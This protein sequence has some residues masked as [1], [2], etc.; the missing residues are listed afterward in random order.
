MLGI[1]PIDK[2]QLNYTFWSRNENTPIFQG[3]KF[4]MQNL[5]SS[6]LLFFH[7]HL[8]LH[9]FHDFLNV[10]YVTRTRRGS[11][12]S[13]EPSTKTSGDQIKQKNGERSTSQSTKNY[14][15]IRNEF[16]LVFGCLSWKRKVVGGQAS[17][18]ASWSWVFPGDAQ[19]RMGQSKCVVHSGRKLLRLSRS[20]DNIPHSSSMLLSS[21]AGRS[22][23][24]LSRT[25]CLL[26]SRKLLISSR[27][28]WMT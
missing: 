21:I 5:S 23:S 2:V 4:G 28:L 26:F 19:E 13:Q 17:K 8:H 7:W 27:D 20:T 25:E 18:F 1:C 10:D 6:F 22:H 9:L 15:V 3:F 16:K 12:P 24:K 14:F 11:S